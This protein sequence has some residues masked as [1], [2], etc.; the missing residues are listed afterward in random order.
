VPIHRVSGLAGRPYSG[1]SVLIFPE[2]PKQQ[3]GE[4]MY[5]VVKVLGGT[6]QADA[7][8]AGDHLYL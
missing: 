2:G 1:L 6:K 5:G 7:P 3:G 4:G 8:D